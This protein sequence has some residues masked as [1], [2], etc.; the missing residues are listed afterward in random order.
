MVG[1]HTVF[2]PAFLISKRATH[3]CIVR[4]YQGY[5]GMFLYYET[6][7]LH[8]VGMHLHKNYTSYV[9]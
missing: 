2:S 8:N 7:L 5:V 3:V 9:G 1:I 4:K 6:S